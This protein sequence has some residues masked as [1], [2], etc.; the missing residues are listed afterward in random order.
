MSAVAESSHKTAIT[1][2]RES[3]IARRLVEQGILSDLAVKSIL[4]FGCGWGDDVAFYARHG[5]EAAGYDCNGRFGCDARPKQSFDLV[6]VVF[7]INVLPSPDDRLEAIRESAEYV[8]P[9]GYL[10]VA[11]RSEAAIKAEAQKG[12]WASFSDGFLSDARKKTF[13]KG[14]TK[15]EI[16]WLFGKIGLPLAPCRLKLDS[17]TSYS[18]ARRPPE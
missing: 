10:L 1:R 15:D 8:K 11:A 14:I 13:Q 2:H 4:D 12:R 18:V 3:Q 5:V 9:G 16:A 7:V 17:A 6:T